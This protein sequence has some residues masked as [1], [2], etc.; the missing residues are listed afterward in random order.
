MSWGLQRADR[1]S[2]VKGAVPGRGAVQASHAATYMKLS[3]PGVASSLK[4]TGH[5]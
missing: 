3:K 2:D 5:K 1:C 4:E